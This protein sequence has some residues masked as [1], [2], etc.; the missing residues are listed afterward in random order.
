MYVCMYVC[1]Y[2]ITRGRL[3]LVLPGF[4]QA[5]C[6]YGWFNLGLTWE[7]LMH[8]LGVPNCS[9]LVSPS[10]CY[11]I[12]CLAMFGYRCHRCQCRYRY[13]CCRCQCR[14]WC[15][16]CRC[17][18]ECRYMCRRLSVPVLPV[19]KLHATVAPCISHWPLSSSKS[20]RIEAVVKPT[21]R[22]AFQAA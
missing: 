20:M 11:G 5:I 21:M 9:D 14:C 12:D 22:G 4:W 18:Y 16:C 19:D 3:G 2:G 8:L 10:D 1:M 6:C 15:K 13:R 17:Q 7:F